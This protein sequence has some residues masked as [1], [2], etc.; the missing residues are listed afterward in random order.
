MLRSKNGKDYGRTIPFRCQLNFVKKDV[1]PILEGGYHF[2][3]PG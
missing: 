3:S 1:Y 2:S